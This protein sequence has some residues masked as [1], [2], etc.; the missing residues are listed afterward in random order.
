MK[1]AV[2][3]YGLVILVMGWQAAA[4][5]LTLTETDTLLAALGA[6][7]FVVSDAVLSVNRFA[8]P[9]KAARIVIMSTYFTAQWLI[10]LS[11]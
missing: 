7:L 4:R 3:A 5:G 1:G 8:Y 2:P 6:A 10:A 9:F 11:I